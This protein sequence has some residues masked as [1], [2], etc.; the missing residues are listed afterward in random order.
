[1]SKRIRV[2][3]CRDDLSKASVCVHADQLVL[4]EAALERARAESGTEYDAVA[5][6]NI[7]MYYLSGGPA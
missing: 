2:R 4:I 3:E 5:L 6:T 1:M 7:C